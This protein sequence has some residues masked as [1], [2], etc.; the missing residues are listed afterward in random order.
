[1]KYKILHKQ[2]SKRAIVLFAGWAMDERPF[3]HLKRNGYDIIIVYD[4]RGDCYDASFLDKYD[5]ICLI[6]WSYGVAIAGQFILE[7]PQLPFT[8]R[9]AVNGTLSP[10]DNEVGIPRKIFDLTLKNL[11][12]KSLEKFYSRMFADEREFKKFMH[13][14]PLRPIKE[15]REELEVFS[16]LD[17]DELMPWLF[18]RILIG[19]NDAIVPVD[20]QRNC[21]AGHK[22]VVETDWS[23]CP[24]FRELI[25]EFVRDKELI[26]DR[27]N[28]AANSY[29]DE[30]TAQ[31]QI[32]EKLLNYWRET[33]GNAKPSEIVEFGVGSGHFTKLYT[34]CFKPVKRQLFDLAP[35]IK[36]VKKADAELQIMKM[37]P[38]SVDAIVAASTLQWF[39]SP[40]AFITRASQ[41]VKPGGVIILSAFGKNHFKELNPHIHSPL[42]YP[43]I[44]EIKQWVPHDMDIKVLQDEEI[45]LNFKNIKDLLEHLRL[46]G[47]NSIGSSSK[48][49]DTRNILNNLQES[50]FG[51]FVLTYHPIY[52]ILQKNG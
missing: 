27:F 18:D 25:E 38:E 49:S 1:M 35:A 43:S 5:E 29:H 50:P 51:D 19:R 6:A 46:T 45:T 21:W 2:S 9:I 17:T 23:H 12:E 22:G 44:E 30:A 7:N 33:V 24:P 16:N 14:K 48:I 26:S 8:A 32:S 20:A 34:E 3:K 40:A 15:T 47:V 39:N 4:Y 13:D 37:E 42:P 36:G 28:S 11:N 10:V 41:V 52:I 31:H